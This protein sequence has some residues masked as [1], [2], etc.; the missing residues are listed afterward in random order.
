MWLS[1][2]CRIS[3]AGR[4]GKGR[5]RPGL[6]RRKGKSGL[7]GSYA[8]RARQLEMPVGNRLHVAMRRPVMRARLV[9][10]TARPAV[11]LRPGVMRPGMVMGRGRRHMVM[12]SGFGFRGNKQGRS[13]GGNAKSGGNA[14]QERTA[15]E[16]GAF[17]TL[18]DDL[19]LRLIFQESRA[20]SCR[21]KLS[22]TR[23]PP[24]AR[25]S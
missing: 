18:H 15:A 25:S 3:H 20:G 12:G 4:I 24:I 7:C 16:A 13:G 17:G 14:T 21:T 6:P 5:R 11:G 8:P 9:M 1:Y 19:L 22:I 10:E 2:P 23:Q